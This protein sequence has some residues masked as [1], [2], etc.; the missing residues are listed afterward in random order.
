MDEFHINYENNIDEMIA[1]DSDD[2]HHMN[3]NPREYIASDSEDEHHIDANSHEQ[4]AS[5]S[6]DEQRMDANP[7]EVIDNT[8]SEDEHQHIND[9]EDIMNVLAADIHHLPAE[10]RD[11]DSEDE[12]DVN[13][14]EIIASDS[15]SEDEEDVN[16][17]EMI[18]SDSD[19]DDDRVADGDDIF[20]NEMMDTFNVNPE[21]AELNAPLVARGNMR[22]LDNLILVIAKCLRYRESY[23][24]MISTLKLFNMNFNNTHF[25]VDMKD[26]WKIVNR[27]ISDFTNI[28]VCAVCWQILGRGKK[29]QINC[30]C[31]MCGPQQENSML[32]MYLYMNLKHQIR[33]ILNKPGMYSDLQYPYTRIKRNI[34]AIEDV[35]DSIL[36]RRLSDGVRL[37]S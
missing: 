9:E 25:P 10:L 33:G 19:S 14:R 16:Y 30:R 29:P 13:H 17:R 35:Y 20:F 27:R 37:S 36:Y 15:D 11:S 12:E 8:D 4:T 2:E 3:V 34:G 1:S 18:V 7:R 22:A 5:D 21:A 24:S 32:G 31:G 28:P 23:K 26:F 6:E